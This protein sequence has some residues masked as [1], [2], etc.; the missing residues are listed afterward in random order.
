M[1]YMI[2]KHGKCFKVVNS[3]TGKVHA[4]C[5]S[6][7]NAKAQVRLLRGLEAGTLK[8]GRDGKGGPRG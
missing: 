3:Q 1:P 6:E 4:E 7:A 5:A 2:L 8:I